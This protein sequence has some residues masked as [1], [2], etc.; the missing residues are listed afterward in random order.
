V[1]SNCKLSWIYWK[2]NKL[3]IRSAEQFFEAIFSREG[4]L[5]NLP[6]F[7]IRPGQ[8]EMALLIHDAYQAQEI[9]CIE[10]GT[11]TG[12]SL[13]Y[14]LPAIYWAIQHKKRTVIST[15]TIALQEQLM[16]KDI[17]FL[18]K[19]LQ[20]DLKVSLAKGMNNYLCL[21]KLRTVEEQILFFPEQEIRLLQ[22]SLKIAEEG[23]RSE[24]PFKVPQPIWDKVSAERNSCDHTRCPHY[25]ECYFFKARRQ[26]L[27]SQLIIVNHHLLLAD[28]K[29]RLQQVKDPPLPSYEYLII[30][31][32][33]H[34]ELI[35]L[36][37]SAQRLDKRYLLYLLSRLFS[38][39]QPESS[40]CRLIRKDL[41]GLNLYSLELQQKIEVDILGQKK[42]CGLQIEQ[43]FTH[44][45]FSKIDVK[46]RIT[47]AFKQT[48]TW[49]EEI[50]PSLTMLA[51]EL[52][53][54]AVIIQDLKQELDRHLEEKLHVHTLELHSL[55]SRLEEESK[56]ISIFCTND[57]S[58]KRVQWLEKTAQNL[59]YVDANLDIA[60]FL[61]K[62]FF[63]PLHAAVLC[64][65]T[66]TTQ[67]SFSFIKRTLGLD[68]IDKVVQEKIYPSPFSFETQ[69]LFLVPNDIPLPS[70]P[71]F[72]LHIVQTIEKMIAITQGSV[73]VLFTSFEML[74]DCFQSLQSPY[75][76]LKQGD[77]PRHMLLEK[78]KQTPGQVLLATDSFWEG[79]DVPGDALKCVIIV[80]LPFAVPSDPLH[81]AYIE[82]IRQDGRNSFLEYSVPQAII[83]FKQGF[84]RL[85][86]SQ[87]DRG[88]IVC[89]DHRLLSKSYG[90]LFLNSLPS[91]KNYF[92][93]KE[94]VYKEMKNFYRNEKY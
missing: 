60:L 41:L 59:S 84:G 43:V 47:D 3:F 11:G 64:S 10:A 23:T 8:K 32:A 53:G 15:H 2:R 35:A 77:L 74:R 61:G 54:L 4:P 78:F 29:S 12:K 33:H 21:K 13:A 30:D 87:Q 19:A 62:Q 68:Q 20:I 55:K 63:T 57:S 75:P 69:A 50:F 26:A 48:Y 80:K 22:A 94:D 40:L 65:A 39:T 90:K 28:Y 42:V 56:K 18:L 45:C 38:E 52:M 89:L 14:L 24:M 6:R 16:N 79:V 92:G 67:N 1:L 51:K 81:E 9:V 91:C 25:K 46:Y 66:L 17:P 37:S 27:E 70:S 86:R 49:K 31:E 85:L 5:Q 7:E 88:C 93:S 76:V 72:L 36:H 71:H 58:L 34:L 73:F 83:Q 44:D 82:A